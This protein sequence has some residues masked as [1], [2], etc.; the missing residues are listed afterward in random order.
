MG[1]LDMENIPNFG[2]QD[3]AA[4]QVCGCPLID[5]I[6]VGKLCWLIHE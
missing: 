3:S 5:L 6:V 4:S 2:L 1:I